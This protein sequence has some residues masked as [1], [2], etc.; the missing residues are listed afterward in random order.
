MIEPRFAWRIADPVTAS[1]A[2]VDAGA[3]LGLGSRAIALLAGRGLSTAGD[4][5]AFFADPLDV[6]HDPR[7]LPDADA[8]VGRIAR[9]RTDREKVMVFGDF[10]AD[11]LT[12]LAILIR[13]LRRLD[14]DTIAYVPNRLDEGHGLSLIAVGA[15]REAGATLIVT[16]DCGSTSVPEIAAARDAGIDVIVTDHHRLPPVLPE[17]VA[18]VN[19][20]RADSR[21]PERRLAGS[22]VAFKLAQL[23]LADEPGGPAAALEFADL[24]TIGSIADL[25]PLLG[26]TRAIV[27]LGLARIAATPRAGI[28]AL[29]ASA[30]VRP[31]A[32]DVETLSFAV[33]PRI[34]AAG[35]VGESRAA[36]ELL[37]TDDRD[38]ADRLAAELEAANR[39]RRDLTTQAISEARALVGQPGAGAGETL[40]ATI[41]HGPWPVGIVGLVASRLVEDHGKPAIVGADLGGV[42]RASCRSNGR[43]D[44]GATLDACG[45][46]F[47]RHGG[48]AGAAGFEIEAGRWPEFVAAFDAL[49][50]SSVPDDPR[51]P[52][53]IDLRL[54]A[55]DVDYALHRDL[56]RLAPCGIGNPEP[57]LVV[58]GLVVTR[59]R[60]ASGGHTQF[61][62]KRRLDVL[63]GIAFGRPDL[64]ET[65]HEG[66]QVDVVARLTSRTFGGY[67]SLQL[68][69]RDVATA[70]LHAARAPRDIASAGESRSATDSVPPAATG[71]DQPVLIVGAAS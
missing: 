30:N 49:A 56:R 28:A 66:D 51:L 57:L 69:I 50:A 3:G 41:V 14:V 7:L 40:S 70:G 25:V 21:Y 46:V 19:P 13:T 22:G 5:S 23:L 44:L 47:L 27:R 26:E 68:D 63:D 15:A 60:A 59:V 48:H 16:V 71:P 58:E 24:A 62:L 12:G 11:G 52:L 8:F 67:E 1:P 6:L 43:L 65:V 33:A 36:A 20:Q 29:L 10:D 55:I 4:V 39:T 9:A 35:R 17:A 32:S 61:T 38:E 64:I 18:I 42:I 2:L 45:D 53:A 34:N 37:L 54:P 31:Q